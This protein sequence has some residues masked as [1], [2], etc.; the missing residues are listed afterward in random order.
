NEAV[1]MLRQ[2]ANSIR[3]TNG[4]FYVNEHGQLCAYQ[5]VSVSHA[6]QLVRKLNAW[7]GTVLKRGMESAKGEE[8]RVKNAEIS[9]GDET[10]AIGCS[11]EGNQISVRVPSGLLP[12]EI[13]STLMSVGGLVV[14]TNNTGVVKLIAG[15]KK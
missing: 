2:A 8:T 13:L 14:H 9:C 7:L 5:Y 11:I 6:S 10:D 12:T 4:P 3:V 1:A 15:S